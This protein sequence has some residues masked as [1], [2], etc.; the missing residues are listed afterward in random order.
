[1]LRA[2]VASRRASFTDFV[3]SSPVC[4]VNASTS[5]LASPERRRIVRVIARSLRPIARD[6]SRTRDFFSPISFAS[7]R[8]SRANTLTPADASPA[9]VGYFTSAS[10][11]V[12]SILTARGRNRFSL[13]ALTIIAR[14]SSATV[15][16]PI[17]RVSLR[18]VDSSGTRSIRLIRQNRRRWIESDTSATSVRYPHR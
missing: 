6:R 11:T 12:E 10:T 9:S 14:V 5:S 16:G 4:S 1:M 3:N 15:S 8:P 13:V 18:T 17:L 2:I 7:L